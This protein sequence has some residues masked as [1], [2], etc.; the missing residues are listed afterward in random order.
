MDLMVG[1]KLIFP[2]LGILM[3][4]LVQLSQLL[5]HKFFHGENAGNDR[6]VAVEIT[7]DIDHDNAV[8]EICVDGLKLLQ[9]SVTL[10]PAD[11]S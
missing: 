5:P 1:E 2:D 10:C 7:E 11:S 4:Y 8:D 6:V 3:E 9:F